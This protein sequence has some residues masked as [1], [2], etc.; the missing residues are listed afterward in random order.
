[1][2][3]QQ[4][5]RHLFDLWMLFLRDVILFALLSSKVAD[6]TRLGVACCKSNGV[7]LLLWFPAVTEKDNSVMKINLDCS[8]LF[9]V[10]IFPP[11]LAGKQALCQWRCSSGCPL[12]A[13]H[14]A[15]PRKDH[16]PLW[17]CFSQQNG[18]ECSCTTDSFVRGTGWLFCN[19]SL[20]L[21]NNNTGGQA[22]R[23]MHLT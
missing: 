4:G 21:A 3:L 2:H 11:L 13:E 16:F 15:E 23:T 14:W 10:G 9:G 18:Q 5:E 19:C 12:R 20:G 1:M 6:K 8:I 7:N 17:S 22:H